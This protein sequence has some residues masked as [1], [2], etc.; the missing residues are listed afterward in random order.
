MPDHLGGFIPGG[1]PATWFPDLWS[2]FVTAQGVRSV[3]DVGC[4][5]GQALDYFKGHG[6]YARGIDGVDQQ[7]Q[8]VFVHDFEHGPLTMGRQYD[9]VWSCEFVEH[10]SEDH[11]DN[12][13]VTF[14]HGDL[15]AMTHAFPGQ[16]GHHHVNCRWPDY[17]IKQMDAW[18]FDWDAQLSTQARRLAARNTFTWSDDRGTH[19]NHF[20]RSGQ[21]FRNRNTLGV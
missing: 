3:L 12:F 18:G 4:G 14:A 1:D 6:C 7:R 16:P 15:V 21:V 2:W 19:V 5:D 8:D 20:M 11:V 9:L 13:L 17:W 10:V